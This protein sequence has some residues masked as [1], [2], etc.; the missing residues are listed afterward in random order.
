MIAVSEEYALEVGAPTPITSERQHE[1]YL[2][3][4]D[5]L[6]PKSIQRARKRSMQRS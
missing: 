2:S 1:E 5:K 4:L 3:V 6:A